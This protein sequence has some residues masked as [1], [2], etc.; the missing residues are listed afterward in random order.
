MN[1][2]EFT[3]KEYL[4]LILIYTANASDGISAEEKEFIERKV[5]E[6][7]T[8]KILDF[9]DMSSEVEIIEGIEQLSNNFAKN[10]KEQVLKDIQELIGV[11]NIEQAAEEHIYRILKK[12]I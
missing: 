1:L 11:D 3:Y 7:L 4:A 8:V 9:F 12:L 6:D 10:R 2:S 5:G